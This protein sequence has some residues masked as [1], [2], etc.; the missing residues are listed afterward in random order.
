MTG[1]K[2]WLTWLVASAALTVALGSAHAQEYP[3]R[4]VRLIAPIAAGGL[5]DSLARTLGARLAERLG[6]A[7]VIENRPGAGGIIGMQ[8]AAKA[9]A[10]GYTLVL[11]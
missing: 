5:T 9:P 1:L 11:V 2:Q 4:P 10:D 3:S 7:V 8:A 6:Q